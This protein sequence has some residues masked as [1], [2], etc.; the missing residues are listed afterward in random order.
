MCL[1]TGVGVART[2]VE[3]CD[4]DED[5]FRRCGDPAREDRE[6]RRAG[7][8]REERRERRQEKQERQ[9]KTRAERQ[10]QAAAEE[11]AGGEV[12]P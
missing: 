2:T 1:E 9:E 12:E 4:L 6:R 10:D 5:F 7:R 3:L 11:K 8:E